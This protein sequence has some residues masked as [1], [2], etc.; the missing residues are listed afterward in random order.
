METI[1]L[2][3]I[4]IGHLLVDQLNDVTILFVITKDGL[5][6]RKYSLLTNQK[7][8][9]L[10]ELLLK[11]SEIPDKNWKVN[12]VELMT[13]TVSCLFIT[14]KKLVIFFQ[15]EIIVTTH[16]SV[17]KIPLA[18]CHRFHTSHLCAASM[19]P[20]CTWDHQYQ[21]CIFSMH[22]SSKHFRQSLTCPILNI[23]SRTD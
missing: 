11:S 3:N 15:K 20:Y 4:R 13:K 10:E 2:E 18:R 14:N 12:Q 16:R 19:D 22:S 1:L 9:F 8:C 21:R 6:L 23:T 17:L 5:R 7:L